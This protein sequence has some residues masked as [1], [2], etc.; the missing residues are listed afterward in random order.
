MNMN[1]TSKQLFWHDHIL[2]AKRD[3]QT[4][5]EYAKRHQ[6]NLQA[7]YYW[8]M[9]LRRKGMLKQS[10]PV[11]MEAKVE[12]PAVISAAPTG[13]RVRLV[14]GVELELAGLSEQLVRWLAAL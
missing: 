11:F 1:L 4:Y 14:N 10:M 7:M 13:V 3:Q 5:A 8:S 12:R 2:A 6:L 9:T